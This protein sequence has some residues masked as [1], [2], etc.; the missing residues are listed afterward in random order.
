MRHLGRGWTFDDLE[1]QTAISEE[2]H[3]QFLHIFIE[4]GSTTLYD[5]CVKTPTNAEEVA[6]HMHEFGI[7]GLHGAVGS[8]DA[9]HVGMERCTCRLINAHSGAKLSMP[10][11]TYNLTVNHRKQILSSTRGHPARWN[12]KT[13]VLFDDF[14]MALN[15]GELDDVEFTLLQ[16]DTEGNVMRVRHK[17]A[18][19]LVDNGHLR[20]AVTVPPCKSSVHCPEI[21]FSEWLESMRKDVECTFGIMKGRFRILKTGIRLHGIEATDKVWLTCCALHNFLLEAD[22]LHAQW[23]DGV[24]S[25]WAGELGNH[26]SGDVRDHAPPFA[27]ERLNSPAAR[28]SYD[29][30]G[31]GVGNDRDEDESESRTAAGQD[32]MTGPQPADGSVRPANGSVR[33]VR[34]LSL[35]YF[36][37][38]LVEHFNILFHKKQIRWPTRMEQPAPLLD[39]EPGADSSFVNDPLDPH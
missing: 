14:V 32:T 11:R 15:D 38:K 24:P 4:W 9:T 16:L 20:W 1:E 33:R 3:R 31:M 2:T 8:T 30:S 5:T 39:I 22:G 23:G 7:A 18:W 37:G 26:N 36:R 35:E 21:R 10:S 29:M 25:E 28:R 6:T 13:L 34:D 19:L 17:G 27:I 12:D